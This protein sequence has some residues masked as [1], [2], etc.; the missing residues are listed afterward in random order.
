MQ[1][2]PTVRIFVKFLIEVMGDVKIPFM[3]NEEYGIIT[4]MFE[5]RV[6]VHTK[7]WLIEARMEANKREERS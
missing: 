6:R 7:H 2:T 5:H 3:M 1:A 4:I